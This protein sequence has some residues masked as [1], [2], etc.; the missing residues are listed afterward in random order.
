MGSLTMCHVKSVHQNLDSGIL[1]QLFSELSVVTTGTSITDQAICLPFLE[2]VQ[3]AAT[4]KHGVGIVA[5][6]NVFREEDVEHFDTCNCRDLPASSSKSGC[7]SRSA[8]ASQDDF[9]SMFL[10]QRLEGLN[11][12]L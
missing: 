2:L 4:S 9:V 11:E 1:G 8:A 12:K 10:N 7:R 5:R 6:I 3:H